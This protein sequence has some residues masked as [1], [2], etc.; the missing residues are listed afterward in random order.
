[1]GLFSPGGTAA[2]AAAASSVAA[3]VAA[4]VVRGRTWNRAA[5]NVLLLASFLFFKNPFPKFCTGKKICFFDA[6][7]GSDPP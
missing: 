1:M 2:F 7:P 3:A 6:H 4:V 5:K